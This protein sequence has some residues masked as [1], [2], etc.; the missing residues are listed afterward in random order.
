MAVL[1]VLAAAAHAQPAPLSPNEPFIVGAPAQIPLPMN[2]CVWAG[3]SFS[4]G[5][6]FCVAA[7]ALETCT[8]GKW[9]ITPSDACSGSPPAD[10]K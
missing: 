8:S 5:A 9:T 6:Q 7:R 10:T 2:G 4:E 3:R 1:F